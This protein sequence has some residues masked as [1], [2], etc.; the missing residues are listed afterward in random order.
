MLLFTII[1]PIILGYYLRDKIKFKNLIITLFILLII[2]V[3][4]DQLSVRMGIWS[5][6]QDKIL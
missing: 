2:G 6:S 1:R 3:V 5:F 4:W